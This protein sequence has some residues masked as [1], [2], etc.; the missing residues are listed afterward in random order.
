MR[1]TRNIFVA[2]TRGSVAVHHLHKKAVKMLNHVLSKYIDHKNNGR[3]DRH[4]AK[5]HSTLN[6]TPG[7]L[8]RSRDKKDCFIPSIHLHSPVPRQTLQLH[9]AMD[10]APR[11]TSMSS[12]LF[13][14]LAI[15]TQLAVLEG[16]P[17]RLV[18]SSLWGLSW[19]LLISS[20]ACS[21]SCSRMLVDP[22]KSP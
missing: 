17:C 3:C 10:N 4:I 21:T 7:I 2:Y 18:R 20:T 14:R 16:V 11:L 19:R 9:N 15:R 5:G 1:L 22:N 13:R 6:S 12:C 8:S